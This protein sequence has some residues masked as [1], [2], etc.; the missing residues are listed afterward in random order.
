[1]L[2]VDGNPELRVPA[3]VLS[4]TSRGPQ[5]LLCY[6]QVVG[7]QHRAVENHLDRFSVAPGAVDDD[8]VARVGVPLLASRV[9]ALGCACSA[10]DT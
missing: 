7:E 1:V 3:A 2:K 8:S 9:R 4:R 6:L 5:A 10:G